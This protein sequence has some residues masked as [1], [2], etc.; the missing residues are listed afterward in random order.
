MCRMSV[1]LLK[2]NLFVTLVYCLLKQLAFVDCNEDL[3]QLP[4]NYE[5]PFGEFFTTYSR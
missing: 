4:A 2:S 1:H 5:Q 3:P